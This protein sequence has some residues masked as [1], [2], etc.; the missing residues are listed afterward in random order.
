MIIKE[1]S[2]GILLPL[3]QEKFFWKSLRVPQ[4]AGKLGQQKRMPRLPIVPPP[5][6]C[7][8]PGPKSVMKG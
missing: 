4:G 5:I 7:I 2:C 1:L 8:L 3:T 6:K